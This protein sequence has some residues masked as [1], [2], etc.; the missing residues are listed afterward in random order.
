MKKKALS[1]VWSVGG[2]VLFLVALAIWLS[3]CAGG[4]AEA[5]PLFVPEFSEDRPPMERLA[6]VWVLRDDN[7]P[8]YTVSGDYEQAVVPTGILHNWIVLVEPCVF[9]D[10]VYSGRETEGKNPIFFF[11]DQLAL[12]ETPVYKVRP[13]ALSY[14]EASSSGEVSV[15]DDYDW[16]ERGGT[17][18]YLVG[19]T[20]R[21]KDNNPGRIYL[22]DDEV[23]VDWIRDGGWTHFF[24]REDV[25]LLN[26]ECLPENI[27]PGKM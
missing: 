11:R 8:S 2:G 19:T 22:T 16:G 15:P 21:I 24:R 4:E 23:P 27:P 20:L 7:T 3:G 18:P 9:K 6:G 1:M 12:E 14:K 17:F 5:K 10:Q 13:G 25:T 26:P